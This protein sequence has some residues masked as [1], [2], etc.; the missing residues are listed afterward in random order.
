[1]AKDNKKQVEQIYTDDSITYSDGGQRDLGGL[2][3]QEMGYL[4]EHEG[5]ALYQTYLVRKQ[6]DRMYGI[7]LSYSE[8]AML[9]V[10]LGG[11]AAF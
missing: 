10:L 1:M 7:V 3:F 11:F 4:V 6:D 2:T 8:E 9:D 5:T